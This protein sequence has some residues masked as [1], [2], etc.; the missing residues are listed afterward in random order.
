MKFSIVNKLK[1]W[2]II[3]LSVLLVGMVLFGVLGYNKSIDYR[4]SNEIDVKVF[5]VNDSKDCALTTANDYFDSINLKDKEYAFSSTVDGDGF[6]IL[7]YKFDKSVE[8]VNTQ[9]LK[10]NIETALEEKGLTLEVEVNVLEAKNS[11]FPNTLWLSIS[12]LIAIVVI[13]VYLFFTEKLASAL[14]VIISGVVSILLF[15][16]MMAITR[17]P[18]SP[19]DEIMESVSAIVTMILSAGLVVRFREEMKNTLEMIE[20]SKVYDANED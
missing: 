2:L 7:K 11:I 17:I 14:S 15:I 9:T 4:T 3:T 6:V 20:K 12:L 19:F 13:F 8:T 1:I 10:S 5:S 16:S 18:A